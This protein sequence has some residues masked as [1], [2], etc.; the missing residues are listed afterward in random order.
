[1]KVLLVEDE[2]RI[3]AF[4]G[5]GL[6]ANGFDVDVQCTGRGALSA[7]RDSDLVVLDLGLPDID[8]LDVLRHLRQD[9]S[10]V[11]IVVLTAR[12]DVDDRV[13]AFELGADDYVPKPF[14]FR[15]LLA[16]VR[17]RLKDKPAI[18]SA[19]TLHGIRLD[20]RTLSASVDGRHVALSAREFSLFV[21]LL[22]NAG[23]TLSREQLLHRVWDLDFDPGTNIVSV[24]VGYLR[25][26]LPEAQIETVRGTGYRL[27]P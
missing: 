13:R 1:M 5:K 26:K 7:A 17:A 15:E 24:Y 23:A 19:V 20:P 22:E 11:P 2:E 8:G 18:A 14:A 10:Q 27:N 6:R 4:V 16:R 25:K 9:G 21:T 12:G 3:A